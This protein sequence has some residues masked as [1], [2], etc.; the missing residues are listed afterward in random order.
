MMSTFQPLAHCLLPSQ[1]VSQK[2]AIALEEPSFARM[3]A[4]EESAQCTI[5]CIKNED[6]VK[7]IR[8]VC[9][10]GRELYLECDYKKTKS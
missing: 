1:T 6:I 9:T 8:V 3:N 2:E 7:G 5:E 4:P 10:C